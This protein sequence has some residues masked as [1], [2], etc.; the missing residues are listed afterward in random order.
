M[1]KPGQLLAAA[2]RHWVGLALPDVLD[3]NVNALLLMARQ[4]GKKYDRRDVLAAL[5]FAGPRDK[6][7]LQKL[8]NE[9]ESVTVAEARIKGAAR[10]LGG[11]RPGRIPRQRK[12]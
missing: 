8:I 2:D 6:V 3:D 4:L 12:P 9:F 11:R 10:S 1:A 7:G 5:V